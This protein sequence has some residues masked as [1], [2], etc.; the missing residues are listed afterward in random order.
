MAYVQL[1]ETD[2]II[3]PNLISYWKAQDNLNDQTTSAYNFT[4]ANLSYSNT[5]G[6]NGCDKYAIFNGTTAAAYI[7]AS[8]N[9]SLEY[10]GTIMFWIRAADIN[11]NS[12]V[13][14]GKGWDATNTGLVFT[15]G[16]ASAAN[17]DFGFYNGAWKIA[18]Y[19]TN[20][21]NNTW[22]HICG[23]YS[24]NDTYLRL[25]VNGTEAATANSGVAVIPRSLARYEMASGYWNG[26]LMYKTSCWMDEIAVLNRCMSA[27]E[28]SDI[29]NGT[30]KLATMNKLG[31]IAR[32]S[33]I[34]GSL[35]GL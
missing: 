22:Y 17:L 33:R 18:S 23:T 24:T 19:A 11:A 12:R 31:K 21:S 20:L 3:D 14:F 30:F 7:T 5:N 29:Y 32:R 10:Y 34:T 35:N 8:P 1:S 4:T 2:I 28:I 16:L 9:L 13:W 15:N 27:Q 25:Y 26:N 6:V